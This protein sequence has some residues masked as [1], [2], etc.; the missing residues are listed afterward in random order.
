MSNI[1]QKGFDSEP[2]Y[3]ENYLKLNEN[4]KQQNKY[5]FSW[6]QNPWK[7]LL[8]CLSVTLIDSFYKMGK[9]YYPQVFLEECKC[10]V[11]RI[12]WTSL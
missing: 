1:R 9:N 8:L 6:K 7:R 2:V 5:K 10:V 3:N 4:L 11:K 12:R